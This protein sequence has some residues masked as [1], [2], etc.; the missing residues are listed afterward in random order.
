MR[1]E[2][3]G[4]AHAEGCPLTAHPLPRRTI[5]TAFT[6]STSGNQA[7]TSVSSDTNV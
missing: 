5:L 1:D 4:G 2:E 3:T 7:F 6:G